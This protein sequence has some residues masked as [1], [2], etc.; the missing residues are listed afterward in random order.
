LTTLKTDE[1]RDTAEWAKGVIERQSTHLIRMVDDLLDV[2]R[3][4]R[5]RV[6]LRKERV[7]VAAVI[8]HALE[9]TQPLLVERQHH[10]TKE[11]EPGVLWAEVDP[12]RIEQVVDNLLT[13]AAKYT[14]PGGRITLEA[15][16][17]ET[18]PGH[19]EIV[20]RVSDT[21]MG[22][23]PRKLPQMFDLFVQGER[24]LARVEGGLGLGLSIVK[25]LTEMHGGQVQAESEGLG[26]GSTFI[27][28]LPAL[29]VS[30]AAPP[31]R[32]AAAPLKSVPHRVLVVDDLD[33]TAQGLARLLRRQ[34][35]TV[36]IAE[37]GLIACEKAH[38]FAPEVVLLDI[39][40]PGMSGY[41]VAQ[42]LRHEQ[43]CS[44]ALIIAITGYG[45]EED[46][47]RAMQAGFDEHLV[48]PV[49]MDRLK[50]LVGD[51]PLRENN[52]SCGN[53]T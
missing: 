28:R 52:A 14:E 6:T 16:H 29:P 10:W 33:D 3:V 30:S 27:V 15:H 18:T 50:S 41:E 49:D 11:Y 23:P 17:E 22:I 48:K 40:L 4:T 44:K 37:D 26:K 31:Q 2:S 42:H 46:R 24:S 1:G 36:E 38:N 7:D 51:A 34:G 20:I 21:G 12:V 8:E 5:G 53:G 39:G 19:P 45:Q 43:C 9:S 25:T 32:K 47:R 35:H 13:N